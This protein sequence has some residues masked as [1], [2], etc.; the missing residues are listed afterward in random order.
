MGYSIKNKRYNY[1]EWIK[2]SSGEVLAR[3]LYDH[4]VDPRETVNVVNQAE[5]DEVVSELEMVCK[6]YKEDI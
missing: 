4:D 1:V 6:T 5:Y 2:L 3:E